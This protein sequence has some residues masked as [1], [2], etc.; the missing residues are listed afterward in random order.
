MAIG[1]GNVALSTKPRTG[2]LAKQYPSRGVLFGAAIPVD[3]HPSLRAAHCQAKQ[4]SARASSTGLLHPV[5]FAMTGRLA[6]QYPSRGMLFGAAIPVDCHPSL[7]AAHCRVKQSSVRAS[8]TGLLHPVGFA[9][10]GRLAK[11]YP[12]RGVL[13]G[14]ALPVDCHPSLRAAHCQAKQ[15]S[16]RVSSTGLLHPVGF[17]MTGR[18]A[19]QYPSRGVLFGAALPVNCRLS[20]R[21]SGTLPRDAIQCEGLLHWIASSSA[22]LPKGARRLLAMTIPPCP[23]FI[24]TNHNFSPRF[25]RC[26]GHLTKIFNIYTIDVV[27][28]M[29][30][31]KR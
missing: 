21:A 9:M 13:F 14:A 7:R 2:R 16:V 30:A 18:P 29:A 6:K 20:L 25:S 24:A 8:S 22:W 31:S 27:R 3:C 11:Q 19:K 17:A 28:I 5:G 1:G 23:G 12:S 4:S 26:Y 15:S 10:T